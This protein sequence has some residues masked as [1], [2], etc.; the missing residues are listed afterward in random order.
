MEGVVLIVVMALPLEAAVV[1]L[2]FGPLRSEHTR[3]PRQ[4]AFWGF[5]PKIS[6]HESRFDEA[7]LHDL[8]SPPNSRPSIAGAALQHAKRFR[9]I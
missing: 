8:Y 1:L 6:E 7:A 3:P 2:W 9:L 4:S 5:L